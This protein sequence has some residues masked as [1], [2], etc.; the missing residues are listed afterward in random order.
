MIIWALNGSERQSAETGGEKPSTQDS[1]EM[2]KELAL[3]VKLLKGMGIEESQ[4]ETIIEAHTDTVNGLKADRDK[5]REQAE[6][7]PTLQRKLEEAEARLQE[8]EDWK[9][10]Y[11]GEHKALKDFQAKVDG[12]RAAAAKA[13]AYRDMLKEAGVD[14]KRLD[15][16]MRVTDLSRVEMEDGKLKEGE[17]LAEAAKTEWADFILKKKTDTPNPATPPKGIKTVDGADP[18]IAKR[19]QERH[20]RLYG[21]SEE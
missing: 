15:T 21:K 7:V 3:T 20:D 1:E 2:E 9:A 14:P 18:D 16:I 11:D 19:M 5:Y 10:K 6:D 12:E 4:I 8:S 13:K 17:K